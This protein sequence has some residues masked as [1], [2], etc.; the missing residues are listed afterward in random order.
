MMSHLSSLWN[1]FQGVPSIV[2]SSVAGLWP[3]VYF[4]PR[5]V[6]LRGGDGEGR[7]R[8][9]QG[10]TQARRAH[11][12]SPF[13]M[14]VHWAVLFLFCNGFF[15]GK[16]TFCLNRSNSHWVLILSLP[17]V[18]A[19]LEERRLVRKPA[20][21]CGVFLKEGLSFR[22][23]IL[24]DHPEG[25]CW[26]LQI[27]TLFLILLQGKADFSDCGIPLYILFIEREAKCAV[28][29]IQQVVLDFSKR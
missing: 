8:K 16:L 26:R 29:M 28:L 2:S 11:V 13:N 24:S 5:A 25:S 22:E 12:F 15:H 9:G 23:L 3:V 14:C 19:S 18:C 10:R 20:G 17:H 6:L 1:I 4:P 7:Q 21:M 27:R